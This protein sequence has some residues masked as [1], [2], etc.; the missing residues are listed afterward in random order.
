MAM[1]DAAVFFYSPEMVAK[2]PPPFGQRIRVG[3]LVM[4]G[5]LIESESGQ[6]TFLVTDGT[7]QIR[8]DYSG[9]L[10]NLFR[11]GQGVVAEGAFE[12]RD[13]F[14]ADRI[15]AKHDENYMPPEVKKAL[16]KA[17][18]ASKPIDRISK[19]AS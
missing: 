1:R 6:L 7:Y 9:L 10:P 3:G 2:S 17:G 15:L 11:E 12:P 19:N 18:V 13:I 5:S 8:V 14:R 16:E 4:P